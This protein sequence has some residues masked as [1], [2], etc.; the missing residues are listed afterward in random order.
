MK[1]NRN[2]WENLPSL[3]PTKRQC[4]S[5]LY[6]EILS[7]GWMHYLISH[8]CLLCYSSTATLTLQFDSLFLL[9]EKEE[10]SLLWHEE[11]SLLYCCR[12]PQMHITLPVSEGMCIFIQSWKRICLNQPLDWAC[13]HSLVL[14]H[15]PTQRLTKF[16]PDCIQLTWISHFLAKHFPLQAR[17]PLPHGYIV[18]VMP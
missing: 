13:I 14:T 1:I 11:M 3:H 10:V 9:P 7:W 17:W 5:A 12:F 4:P 18:S 2:I 8:S 6:T 15:P 16:W